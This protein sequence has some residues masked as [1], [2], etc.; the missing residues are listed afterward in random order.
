MGLDETFPAAK[1]IW[2]TFKPHVKTPP[3]TAQKVKFNTCLTSKFRLHSVLFPPN[4]KASQRTPKP[5]FNHGMD[6]SS[7]PLR[8]VIYFRGKTKKLDYAKHS[9]MQ[10]RSGN[11]VVAL[12]GQQKYLIVLELKELSPVE[13]RILKSFKNICQIVL[14]P[15]MTKLPP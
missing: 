5:A 2:L 15:H 9:R 13:R 14:S 12:R 4:K 1:L 10:Q 3:T 7:F 6:S 8:P 11:T